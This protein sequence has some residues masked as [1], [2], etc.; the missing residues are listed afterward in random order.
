MDTLNFGNN[1]KEVNVK[2]RTLNKKIL[3]NNESVIELENVF[4]NSNVDI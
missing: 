1:S 2:V 3:K 4:A